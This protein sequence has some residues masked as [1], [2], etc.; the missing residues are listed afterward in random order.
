MTSSDP[1]S[2]QMFLEDVHSTSERIINRARVVASERAAERAANPSGSKEQIQL[3]A[4]DPSTVITFEVPDGPPP[5]KLEITGEGADELDPVL[6]R[7]FLQKRWEIFEGFGEAVKKAVRSKS[8]EKVNR[9]LGKMDVPEAEEV[10]RQLQEAG[11]LSVRLSSVS[12]RLPCAP[13]LS[14][15]SN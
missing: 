5:E 9:V 14:L 12:I 7:E 6:V 4:S 10:V 1:K 2:L 3:V 13:A 15:T 11:I 8:L